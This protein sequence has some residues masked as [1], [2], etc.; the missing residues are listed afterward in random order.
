MAVTGDTSWGVQGCLSVPALAQWA[1]A[2]TGT[3][4]PATESSWASSHA[5]PVPLS[6]DRPVQLL[7]GATS[8]QNWGFSLPAFIPD[9]E[10]SVIQLPLEDKN[11][12]TGHLRA[13]FQQSE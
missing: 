8:G 1:L 5:C 4:R 6:L 12:I 10:S 2:G 9:G 3:A 7:A 11:G 13:H